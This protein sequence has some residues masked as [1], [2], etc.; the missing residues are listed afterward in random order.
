MENFKKICGLIALHRGIFVTPLEFL[1]DVNKFYPAIIAITREE[2]EWTFWN[3]IPTLEKPSETDAE[4]DYWYVA[5]NSISNVIPHVIPIETKSNSDYELFSIEKSETDTLKILNKM[6]FKNNEEY[7]K[8]ASLLM[9][10]NVQEWIK[11]R[12]EDGSKKAIIEI[13][14]NFGY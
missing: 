1:I 4:F 8:Y 14:K 6:G 13:L 9:N 11:W 7:H 3:K 12:I 2:T 10:Y 5:K